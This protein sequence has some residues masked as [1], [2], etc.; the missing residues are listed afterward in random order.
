M[1]AGE[2]TYGLE[3]LDLDTGGGRV[4]MDG[5]PE[6]ELMNPAALAGHRAIFTHGIS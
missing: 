1:R 3:A 2:N 6:P 4:F 5:G